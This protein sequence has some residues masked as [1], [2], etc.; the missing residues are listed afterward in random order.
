MKRLA[1]LGVKILIHKSIFY[2]FFC[3]RQESNQQTDACN[4]KEINRKEKFEDRKVLDY[5]A[6]AQSTIRQRDT[7]NSL[8]YSGIYVLQLVFN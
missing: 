1:S 3:M 4:S 5:W 7:A 6:L 2:F 8:R